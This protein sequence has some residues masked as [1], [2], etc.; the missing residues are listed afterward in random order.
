M[1]LGLTA[2]LQLEQLFRSI[3]R[4]KENDDASLQSWHDKDMACTIWQESKNAKK[5]VHVAVTSHLSVPVVISL[6]KQIISN[7]ENNCKIASH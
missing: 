6:K 1:R 2:K 5:N 3:K 7:S 4:T